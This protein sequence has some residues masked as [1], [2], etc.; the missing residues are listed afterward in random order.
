MRNKKP[1]LFSP[2]FP[3]CHI[4]NFRCL[5]TAGLHL[6]AV[7]SSFSIVYHSAAY[8]ST[9]FF[10]YSYLSIASCSLIANSF[11]AFSGLDLFR[12]L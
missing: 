2:G 10:R 3:V 6:Q 5:L 4:C 12:A 8:T 1:G 9:S 7:L 11:A